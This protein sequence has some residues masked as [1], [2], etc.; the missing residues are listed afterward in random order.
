M[1]IDYQWIDWSATAQKPQY[2]NFHGF[3]DA[4]NYSIGFEYRVKLSERVSLYPRLGYRHFDAPWASKTDLPMTGPF[5]LVLDTKGQAF[6][7]ATYGA[8]ISWTTDAGKVRSVDI[9]GDAGGD[10]INLAVGFTMEF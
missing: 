10:A 4:Q 5:R 1:T 9:A 7:L 8:G 2:D 3:Q 6:N